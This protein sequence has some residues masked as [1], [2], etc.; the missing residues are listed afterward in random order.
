VVEAL[1]GCDL[2]TSLQERIFTPLGMTDTSFSPSAGQRFRMI[3]VYHR[4]PDGGLVAGDIDLPPEPEFWA[5]G[6]GGFSTARD[7]GRFMAAMLNDG[8]LDGV[9]VLRA[10]TVALAFTD[11]LGGVPYPEVMETSI[12]EYSNDVQSFPVRQGFGLGFHVVLEGLPGLR[13]AGS[14]DWAGLFNC[15][16]WIDRSSGVAGA[17]FTQVLPFFDGAILETAMGIEGAIYAGVTAEA[18]TTAS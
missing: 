7:Y 4:L 2:A 10:E 18:P 17:F 1:D 9:R 8:E 16:Y 15:Y 3:P 12:P 11:H 6:H 14:G 13:S 5:G